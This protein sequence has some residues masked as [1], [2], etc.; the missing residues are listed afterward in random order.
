MPNAGTIVAAQ[1]ILT[2]ILT[3]IFLSS[4]IIFRIS[5]KIKFRTVQDLSH[6]FEQ[7]RWCWR[8]VRSAVLGQ[9]L[10]P[11]KLIVSRHLGFQFFTYLYWNP[12]RC[13]T[14]SL[15][16]FNLWSTLLLLLLAS[17]A[18]HAQLYW[19][20]QFFV[21]SFRFCSKNFQ[22]DEIKIFFTTLSSDY[23]AGVVR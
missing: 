4:C 14:T 21:I 2:R 8:C 15:V 6:H 12:K 13:E 20:P 10:K 22:P 23:G 5:K 1:R 19:N 17:T 16:G 11:S 18:E 9:S 3:R 7:R